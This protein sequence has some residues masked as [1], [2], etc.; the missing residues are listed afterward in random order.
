MCLN[1]SFWTSKITEIDFT[2]NISGMKFCVLATLY[3]VQG[4]LEA[5]TFFPK[6]VITILRL[7]NGKSKRSYAWEKPLR[8]QMRD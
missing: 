1:G 2:Y 8:G 5:R 4:F 7:V 6:I 3:I